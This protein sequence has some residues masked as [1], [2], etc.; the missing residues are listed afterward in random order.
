MRG[1]RDTWRAQWGLTRAKT[2][3]CVFELPEL[4][5][6]AA[7]APTERDRK[8]ILWWDNVRER[9]AAERARGRAASPTPPR[10]TL[11]TTFSQLCKE[12]LPHV[13]K[14]LHG[15]ARK[16]NGVRLVVKGSDKE[17]IGLMCRKASECHIWEHVGVRD[18]W[19]GGGVRELLVSDFST[20][21]RTGPKYIAGGE[22]D[23][24][25]GGGG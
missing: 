5:R 8:Y 12:L 2:R 1:T 9:D 22:C 25:R 20:S 15:A 18:I 4:E 7:R 17:K 6:R 19:G 21:R 13:R 10:P 3:K 16:H 24:W 14:G 11:T 23:I